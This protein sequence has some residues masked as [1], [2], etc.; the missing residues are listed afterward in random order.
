MGEGTAEGAELALPAWGPE[1]NPQSSRSQGAVVA[2]S[3]PALTRVSFTQGQWVGL[4][5]GSRWAVA[6]GWGVAARGFISV[7]TQ[8]AETGGSLQAV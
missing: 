3:E 4:W 7:H 8:E 2:D 5:G 6:V 1:S